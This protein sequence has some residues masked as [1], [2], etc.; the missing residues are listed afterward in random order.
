MENR[1]NE[2]KLLHTSKNFTILYSDVDF[3]PGIDVEDIIPV[4][5]AAA[6]SPV[7]KDKVVVVMQDLLMSECSS[8]V[9]L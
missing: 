5:Q 2:C 1:G 3:D 4:L 7:Y 9:L 8:W 6:R